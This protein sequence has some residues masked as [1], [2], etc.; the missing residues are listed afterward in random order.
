MAFVPLQLTVTPSGPRLAFM[1]PIALFL[2]GA[3]ALVPQAP[4]P[5]GLAAEMD[6]IRAEAAAATPEDQRA[7]PSARLERAKA[8]LDAGRPLLALYLFEMPWESAKAWSFVKASGSVTTPEAFV[9]KWA[10]AGEP[11]TS[12]ATQ[13]GRRP[14]LVEAMAT[15]AEARGVTT[16]HASRS[17]GEDSGPLGGLYY[18]GESHAVMQF[19]AMVR[20]MEW[21]A[22]GSPPAFRSLS[23]ELAALDTDMTTAYETMDRTSHS[24]YIVASA[25]LKQARTLNDRGQYA[26]ALFQYLLSRYVFAA[27]RGPAAAEATPQ[28]I[29][30]A[31]QSL[32]PGADHSIAGLF[33]QLAGEGVASDVPAQRRGA[34]ATIED[35]IPAYL[36]AIA[37][38]PAMTAA[39]RSADVTITL[40]RWPFT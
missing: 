35:V 31:R 7:T 10:A 18:L 25:A 6:R 32:P 9:R 28:R 38:P 16:Y 26:G 34:A 33:L 13:D 40:V 4:A 11:R 19:A 5:P 1:R 24:T 23:A 37:A 8:A 29:E 20:A 3:F 2:A 22:A 14:A 15:A 17:Y 12:A 27:L 36:R 39:A 21:P 30:E